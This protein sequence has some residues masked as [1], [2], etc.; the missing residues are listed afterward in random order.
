VCG[1]ERSPS[2][3]TVISRGRGRNVRPGV[4][5][6]VLLSDLAELNLKYRKEDVQDPRHASIEDLI[7]CNQYLIEAL[8]YE[9]LMGTVSTAS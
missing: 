3:S 7:Q 9:I 8:I 6:T 5:S 1:I 2:G 4:Y